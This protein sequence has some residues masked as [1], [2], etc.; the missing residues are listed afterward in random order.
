MRILLLGSAGQVGRELI[1]PLR[2][3]HELICAARSEGA[4]WL[5][6]LA[7]AKGVARMLKEVD[8]DCVVNAAAYTAVDAA[9]AD[10]ATA[11]RVNTDGPARLAAWATRRDAL[12]VH[13]STDY[14]YDGTKPTPYVESDPTAPLSVYG[15]TKLDGDLAV[16]AS[17]CTAVVLRT[18]WVYG[19]WGRNFLL[20]MRNLMNERP[21]V[22]V[23][24]DQ[25]GAPTWSR[26]IAET[27][28][29]I[30]ERLPA[31]RARR[32]ALRGVYH[33]APTGETTWFGFARAIRDAL[34]FDCALQPITTAEY[35][36][37]ARRPASSRLDTGRLTRTFG[38]DLPE[39]TDCL[40]ACVAELRATST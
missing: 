28:A 7:D 6:D 24:D 11:K 32:N 16:M 27:T 13:Y 9:E 30:L 29:S 19:S 31:D 14:V 22:N 23:V 17:G 12:L 33:L 10:P 34:A 36:T 35:P 8:P 40:K 4:D 26:L 5:I 15:Q 25:F 3:D 18:S 21:L 2:R 38:I 39:W 1:R 37:P 20:T